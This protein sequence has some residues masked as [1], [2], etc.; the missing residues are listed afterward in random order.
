MKLKYFLED[1]NSLIRAGL[2][3]DYSEVSVSEFEYSLGKLS[4]DAPEKDS[5][6]Q[7]LESDIKGYSED[8]KKME[9]EIQDLES[10]LKKLEGEKR[11]LIDKFQDITDGETNLASEIDR[12]NDLQNEV[13]YWRGISRNQTVK[14]NEL[15]SDIKKLRAR[16][17]KVEVK[18]S[19]TTGRLE[20]E[21]QGKFYELVEREGNRI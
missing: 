21:W 4:F 10:N 18:R 20:V 11:K 13:D 1:I 8:F 16:K 9:D 19:L 7:D 15:N 3:N 2:L 12:A 6:I 14:I 17:N 5:K